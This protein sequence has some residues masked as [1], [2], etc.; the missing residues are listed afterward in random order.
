MKSKP[1][2]HPYFFVLYGV[3]SLIANNITQ[4]S[5]SS[6]KILLLSTVACTVV[7]LFFYLILKDTVKASLLSS[8]ATILIFTY[9]HV[10]SLILANVSGDPIVFINLLTAVWWLLFFIWLYVVLKVLK[11]FDTINR[12]FTAVSII[13]LIFP[14]ISLLGFYF[15]SIG[16]EEK[17]QE[18]LLDAW[19]EYG[20][21]E[22]ENELTSPEIQ[23]DIYYIIMDSYARSDVIEELYGHDN[24]TFL[25]ELESREFYVAN[26]SRSNY[27]HTAFSLSS[28]MNMILINSLPDYMSQGISF[29]KE[30]LVEEASIDVLQSNRLMDIL[31]RQDYEIVSFD[32]GFESINFPDADYHMVPQTIDESIY[33]SR[34]MFEIFILELFGGNIFKRSEDSGG[35]QVSSLYDAHRERITYTFDNIDQFAG[36][37]GNYFIFVHLIAPHPPYVFG[38]NGEEIGSSEVFT[39][40]DVTQSNR[41][42]NLYV[43]ELQYLNKQIINTVDQI[44]QKSDVPPIIIIQSDHGSRL[45]PDDDRSNEVKDK[46]LFPILN[47]YLLP[48]TNTETIL[49]P[50]ISP[51]NTFRIILNSY[52]GT[53]LTLLDD[54][55][56]DWDRYTGYDFV[57]VC[58]ISGCP[59]Q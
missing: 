19:A 4:I 54:Q 1:I 43:G 37:D 51:V 30:W 25:E 42:Y 27:S 5:I 6:L 15:Q 13:L 55:S 33:S 18:F 22:A 45:Y 28:S 2:L 40:D 32:T 9:G 47:A 14:I 23:P 7:L 8:V 3:L 11:T 17:A 36:K 57:P 53:N 12:Y 20:I 39:L 26:E 58:E 10:K 50:T 59:E 52:F 46:V 41:D 21:T 34:N 49:Y 16:K 56:Y 44:L 35:N 38:P 31:R 24:S 29:N 48:G